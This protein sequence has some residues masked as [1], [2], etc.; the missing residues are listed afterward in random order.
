[1]RILCVCDKGVNRSVHIASL[2]KFS[3]HD[4]LPV[5]V[6]T[7][8]KDTLDLLRG[9]ADR[10]IVTDRR[11]LEVFPD[12]WLW[13]LRDEPRPFNPLLYRHIRRFMESYS[14]ELHGA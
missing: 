7:A 12:A 1:M 4:T 10:V 14:G 8:D 13:E 6:D 2:L 9:W 5:G 11:H 3:G